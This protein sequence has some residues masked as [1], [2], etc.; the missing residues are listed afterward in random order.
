MAAWTFGHCFPGEFFADLRELFI[1]VL[2]RF[3]H[4]MRTTIF[5][6]CWPLASL[7]NASRPFSMS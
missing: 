1:R 5:P 7:A 2:S 3:G 6:K 4:A